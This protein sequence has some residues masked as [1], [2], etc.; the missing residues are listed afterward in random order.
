MP[1]SDEKY[2]EKDILFPISLIISCLK[3]HS[4][5]GRGKKLKRTLPKC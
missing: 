3:R 2:I 5:F 1:F 4:S